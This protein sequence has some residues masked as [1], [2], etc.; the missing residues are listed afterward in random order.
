MRGDGDA[1]G[2]AT[3]QAHVCVCAPWASPL[4]LLNRVSSADKHHLGPAV[5]AGALSS[6]QIEAVVYAFQA[7]SGPF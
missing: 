7:R 5:A 3:A 1:G 6:L 4:P 2:G